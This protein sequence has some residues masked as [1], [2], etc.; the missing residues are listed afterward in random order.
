MKCPECEA[1]M[2]YDN[3]WDCLPWNCPNCGARCT[4]GMNRIVRK[5]LDDSKEAAD[6]L[7]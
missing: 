7:P 2:T 4:A 1:E 5:Q 6:D 3:S